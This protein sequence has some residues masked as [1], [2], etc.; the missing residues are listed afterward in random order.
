MT[1]LGSDSEPSDK[2]TPRARGS[3]SKRKEVEGMK[4]ENWD[5]MSEQEKLAEAKR[6]YGD[7]RGKYIIAQALSIASAVMEKMP[8]EKKE[9][10]NI[11]DMKMLHEMLFPFPFDVSKYV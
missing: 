2:C 4:P 3:K 10:S 6:L 8:E 7:P 9:V 5:K 11:E 1:E